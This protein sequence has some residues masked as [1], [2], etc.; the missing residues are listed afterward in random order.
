LVHLLQTKC[1]TLLLI[2]FSNLANASSLIYHALKSLPPPSNRVNW[3]GF[4]V[5][6]PRKSDELILGPFQGKVACQTITFGKGVCGTAVVK[7]QTQLVPN[8]EQFPGHIACDSESQSEVV[9]PIIQAG[10]VCISLPSL[11]SHM[12]TTEDR[13]SELSTSIVRRRTGLMKTT[14]Q[15][16][17]NWLSC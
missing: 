8:V 9:V 10:R 4:Y 3:A 14:G 15:R 1:I 2:N 16:W 17:R 6:N 12:L 5:L 11:S 7:Q 13:L